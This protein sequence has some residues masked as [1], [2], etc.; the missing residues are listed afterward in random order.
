LFRSILTAVILCASVPS[1]YA[2]IEECHVLVID[3]HA[4]PHALGDCLKA[5]MHDPPSARSR[6]YVESRE[7]LYTCMDEGGCAAR[8]VG[9]AVD[10]VIYNAPPR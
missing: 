9:D 1:A 6:L 2:G 5:H 4:P 3:P 10:G 7:K 8:E